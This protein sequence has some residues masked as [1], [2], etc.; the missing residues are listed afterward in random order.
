MSDIAGMNPLGWKREH[1]VALLMAILAG[2]ALGVVLGYLVYAAPKGADGGIGF[3]SWL[4]RSFR[5]SYRARGI[6]WALFGAFFGGAAVYLRQL[7]RR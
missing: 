4:R 6:E 5:W 3:E 2:A 7:L 1:Q